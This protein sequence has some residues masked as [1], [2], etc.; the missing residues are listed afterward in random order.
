MLDTMVGSKGA[1]VAFLRSAIE[2]EKMKIAALSPLQHQAALLLLRKCLSAELRHLQRTLRTDDML[3]EWN[4]LDLALWDEIKRI[5]RR[6]DLEGAEGIED[7]AIGRM[8]STL[9]VRY[10][11]LGLLSHEDCSPHAS[12][13]ATE[14]S[15]VMVD[16]LFGIS[17]EV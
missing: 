9:P 5:R 10:G 4:L 14:A 7:D 8:C 6:P 12:A 17:A 2:L 13:A 15:D 1:P 3:E 16:S 11:G